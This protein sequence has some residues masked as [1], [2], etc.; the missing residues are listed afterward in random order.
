MNTGKYA[1]K[2]ELPSTDRSLISV[3]LQKANITVIMGVMYCCGWGAKNAR[4][5]TT[6]SNQK[7]PGPCCVQ[8][9]SL[10]CDY[11]SHSGADTSPC[12]WEFGPWLTGSSSN[13][14]K[15]Q[16]APVLST[17]PTG[18]HIHE[19]A[20]QSSEPQGQSGSRIEM[21]FV[22]FRLQDFWQGFDLVLGSLSSSGAGG[23]VQLFTVHPMRFS[24]Q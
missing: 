18:Y 20:A 9:G 21:T 5:A 24:N 12:P 8:V 10:H 4:S 1:A 22:S 2:E 19:T 11:R 15:T 16:H 3:I 6:E 7:A 14:R 13:H 23:L 17:S